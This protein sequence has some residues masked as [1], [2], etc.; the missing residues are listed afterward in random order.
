MLIDC[1]CFG[2][3]KGRTWRSNAETGT[4]RDLSCGSNLILKRWALIVA[5]KSLLF[6]H[7]TG[8]R[9]GFREMRSKKGVYVSWA[10]Q[11]VSVANGARN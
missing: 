8:D 6:R 4:L 7:L 10:P 11:S 5:R 1:L 2:G 9:S 3:E